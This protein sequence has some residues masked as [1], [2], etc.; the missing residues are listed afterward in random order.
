MD[1]KIERRRWTTPA[2][3]AIVGGGLLI[4][5]IAW[6]LLAQAGV[7]SQQ[8]DRQR[9]RIGTAEIQPFREFIV[10]NSA[11][12]A[13]RSYFLE[14]AEGGRV[15]EIFVEEGSDVRAG[16]AILRM[17]NT[18]LQ[19]DILRRDD[20]YLEQ[21]NN[22]QNTQLAMAQLRRDFE[23]RLAELDY[24]ILQKKRV[25][26]QNQT[27]AEEGLISQ[28][29][30][31]QSHDEYLFFEDERK[32]LVANEEEDRTFR[33]AQ[34]D[35]ARRSVERARL[36]L[37]TAREK[38]E[39]LTLIAP[40]DG[41]LTALDAEIG[42]SKAPGDRLGQLDVLDDLNLRAKIDQHY[43]ARV[44]PG[45]EAFIEFAGETSK[46]LVEKVFPEVAEGQFE[47]EL[48]FAEA[49]P[50]GLKRGQTLQTRLALGDSEQALVIPR[51][52][53]QQSTG[54]QWVFLVEGD[55]RAAQR[56]AIRL[57]RQN[58]AYLEILE[59]LSPGDKVVIS[60]YTTFGDAER[61]KIER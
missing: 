51:G 21:T 27:L 11:V 59:G 48:R 22:L 16:Q 12:E 40:A 58:D 31:E 54:G 53:F 44:D 29:E 34:V 36:N 3:A 15:E 38:L 33:V 23:Q 45:Q 57:G 1:R 55:G 52:G 13:E 43:I 9:L 2:V 42:E 56:Q 5:V 7:Q 28:L 4:A 20:L 8:V 61:L 17:V 30:F 25:Y 47:A 50:D 60:G 37:A 26:E 35:Q 49:T 6:T 10:V 41:R 39:K 32:R 14:T 24:Q 18:D 46:L 19:L